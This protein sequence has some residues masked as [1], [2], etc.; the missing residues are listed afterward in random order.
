MITTDEAETEQALAYSTVD[1]QQYGR[2]FV[3]YMREDWEEQYV[4]DAYTGDLLSDVI[5]ERNTTIANDFD[6][7]FKYYVNTYE[8]INGDLRTQVT[9]GLD[10]YDVYDTHLYSFTSC[11]QSGYCY[12]LA[13]VDT[14]DLTAE[15]WDQACVEN[16]SV[17]DKTYMITGDIN[18]KT[19][20][21]TSCFTVNKRLLQ[22]QK[23]SVDD[24]YALA[25]NGQWTLDTL[26]EYNK[27]LTMDLNGDDVID[28]KNDRYGL[29]CWSL[30]AAFSLFYGKADASLP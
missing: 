18:P 20:L 2:D 11:A 4:A 19:M 28:F 3:I 1:K 21:G 16:L 23:K 22:S 26:Y 6:I 12:N 14:L 9:G 7:T 5:Y 27:D 15:W 13:N 10:E 17:N 24:L 25:H 30:D 8:R 29:V